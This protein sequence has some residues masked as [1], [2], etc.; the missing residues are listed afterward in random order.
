VDWKEKYLAH[1]VNDL[2]AIS[3]TLRVASKPGEG[4]VR[5]DTVQRLQ[6]EYTDALALVLE[7]ASDLNEVRAFHACKSLDG[8]VQSMVTTRQPKAAAARVDAAR[9][10]LSCGRFDSR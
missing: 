8:F 10:E 3:L 1:I 5:M 6:R 9:G 2:T 7:E 4:A